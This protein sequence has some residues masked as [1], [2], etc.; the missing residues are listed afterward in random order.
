MNNIRLAYDVGMNNGDDTEYYL[1]KGYR[2]IGIDANPQ[3][4]DE[5]ALR[6]RNEIKSGMLTILNVGVGDRSGTL[7]FYIDTQSHTTS[8]FVPQPNHNN[9][10]SIMPIEVRRLS[11]II[12]EYGHPDLCKV[13]VEGLDFVVL[14][15][16]FE[17]GIFPTLLSAEAHIIDVFC[18]MVVHGYELFKIVQGAQV[19]SAH[20]SRHPIKTLNG[21]MKDFEFKTNSSGPFGDDY[22]EPW[23]SKEPAILQLV[24]V[25]NTWRDV[26]AKHVRQS[27]CE[28]AA[29]DK[30][31]SDPEREVEQAFSYW[32]R[33]PD[34]AEDAHYGK[35]GD[36]GVHGARAHYAEHGRFEETRKWEE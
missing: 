16:I 4:C 23:L 2:V 7:D 27:Y 24:S 22:P 15:Q 3:L 36:L 13:D 25:S 6:F 18:L 34:V 20:L 5:V 33:Y 12:A 26:Q 9:R 11:D 32:R 17:S 29:G 14:R 19:G 31:T 28:Q 10:Y 30:E 35:Y 21:E 1:L 8:T